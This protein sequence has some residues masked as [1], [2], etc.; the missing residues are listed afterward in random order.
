MLVPA[1]LSFCVGFGKGLRG[2]EVEV[3]VTRKVELLMVVVPRNRQGPPLSIS[4]LE[5]LPIFPLPLPAPLRH[6]ETLSPGG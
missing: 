6:P 2:G 3:G 1:S 5:P 4:D